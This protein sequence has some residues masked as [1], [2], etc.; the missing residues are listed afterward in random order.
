VR[1]QEHEAEDRLAREAKQKRD[2]ELQAQSKIDQ[3]IWRN[4]AMMAYNGQ[5]M[6]HTANQPKNTDTPTQESAK[7]EP[8]ITT[9]ETPKDTDTDKDNK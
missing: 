2:E 5:T 6:D 9:P 7:D 3:E 8:L 1:D 4:S